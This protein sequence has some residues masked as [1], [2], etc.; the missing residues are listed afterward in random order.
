ME[1]LFYFFFCPSEEYLCRALY[2]A[3][4]WKKKKTHW[5]I[6]RPNSLCTPFGNWNLPKLTRP[7]LYRSSG[8]AA[9]SFSVCELHSSSKMCH[10]SL[11]PPHFG[12]VPYYF[13]PSTS[14]S[15]TSCAMQSHSASTQQMLL[16]LH[17]IRVR[18]WQDALYMNY[19]QQTAAHGTR[20]NLMS[21]GDFY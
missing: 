11:Q 10:H 9:F 13:S 19:R 4:I 17:W 16:H 8:Y 14:T 12:F 1:Y 21:L 5:W 3:T 6:R 15:P 7:I 18:G 20:L 2:V